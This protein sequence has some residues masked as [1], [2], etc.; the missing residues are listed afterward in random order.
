MQAASK[1]KAEFN[2]NKPISIS[3]AAVDSRLVQSGMLF[4]ALPGAK[5]DGHNFIGQAAAAGAAAA[6]VSKSYQG[7]NFGLPLIRFENVLSALQGFSKHILD[8][9][10]PRII[11]VTGSL[12]KTTTKGFIATLLSQKYRV[13]ASPGNSNSQIG[14]PL[15]IINHTK[16][17]D[18]ILILEMGMTHPGQL[19]TLVKIAPP[20]I[21]ILTAVEMV[22]ACNFKSLADIANAKAEIFSHPKTE[23]AIISRDIKNFDQI[24]KQISFSKRS[25]SIHLKD[26]DYF[27]ESNGDHLTLSEP[28]GKVKLPLLKVLGHHNL[29]NFL[30]AAIVARHLNV[31]WEEISNTIPKL[32]LP[33]KRLQLIEREGVTYINDAY[34]ATA[35]SVK[36][37]LA[38]LPK[39]KTGGKTI[40]VFG[41]TTESLGNFAEWCHQEVAHASLVNVDHMLC[42]GKGCKPIIEIWEKAKKPVEL[43]TDFPSV[44]AALRK[45]VQKGDVVLL[46]GSNSHQLWRIVEDKNSESRIQN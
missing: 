1:Q 36:A 42:L 26:A 29:H 16:P 28:N 40:F 44:L 18:E 22:H 4:F 14:L 7:E 33:E 9:R 11:A 8:T 6:V 12:G 20:E 15:T 32:S 37:A 41:D 43:F 21:A 13:A 38:S 10:K 30:A 23:L 31:S 39:P 46:K 27:L 25:F 2:L 34:N 17:E 35:V 3:G 24:V 5:T 19:S 45:I